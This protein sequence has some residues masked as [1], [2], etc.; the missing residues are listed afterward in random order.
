MQR[1]IASNSVSSADYCG[2]M[3]AAAVVAGGQGHTF[4]VITNSYVSYNKQD[5]EDEFKKKP[6]PPPTFS[7][8]VTLHHV[9]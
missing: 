8:M 5:N 6:T 1:F 3:Q 7:R 9:T 4:L 2:L